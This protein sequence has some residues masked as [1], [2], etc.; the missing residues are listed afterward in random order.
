MSDTKQDAM[1]DLMTAFKAGDADK[2]SLA[3]QRAVEACNYDDEKDSDD[4]KE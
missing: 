2:A 1:R 3:F 4:D